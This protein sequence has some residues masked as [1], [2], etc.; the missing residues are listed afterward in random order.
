MTSNP[1]GRTVR[2]AHQRTQKTQPGLDIIVSVLPVAPSFVH[3]RASSCTTHIE[4]CA[5]LCTDHVCSLLLCLHLLA[6][7]LPICTSPVW[8]PLMKRC[9]FQPSCWKRAMEGCSIRASSV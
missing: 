6:A 9:I 1:M 2:A 4:Y 7:S 8:E 5:R 3:Y